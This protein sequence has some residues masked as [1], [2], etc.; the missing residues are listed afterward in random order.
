MLAGAVVLGG[1]LLGPQALSEDATAAPAVKAW[2]DKADGFASLGGGTTGGA[3]GKTVTVTSFAEL[4]KYATAQDPYVIKVGG[5]LKYPTMGN[6][7]RVA[8]NKTVIGAG[9]KGEI[10]G[11]GF[12][13]KKGVSNVIIRN[14]TIRDTRMPDD[15]P[16]D[17]SYDYDAI[18]IDTADHIWIDHNRLERMNDGLIDSRKDTTNLTVS[19]N[20]INENHKTFGIGWT[21]NVTSQVTIHHNWCGTQSRNPSIDNVANAHL[22]NNYLQNTGSGNWSRGKSN[23]VIENRGLYPASWTPTPVR[24]KADGGGDGDAIGGD[25]NPDT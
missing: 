13:L 14:L 20:I 7:V 8:S 24:G 23:T 6:E 1:S 25:W 4:E 3:A 17:D 11:G 22:Y 10:V 5:T 19:W 2:P 9:T 21:D 18:Q 12:F 15:D 16:D